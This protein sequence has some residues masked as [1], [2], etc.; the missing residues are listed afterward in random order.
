MRFYVKDLEGGTAT[1]LGAYAYLAAPTISSLT[2]ATG[3]TAGGNT[4]TIHGT[5][6][7]TATSVS[8]GSAQATPTVV[9]DTQL[10]VAVP[11]GTAAGA[12]TIGV[13][14][15]GGSVTATTTYQ[16]VDTPT[17]EAL[18]PNAGPTTGG[19][20]VTITGT[21]FNT[22][23]A[24]TFGGT[25]ASFTVVSPTQIV[26]L[27]PAGTAGFVDVTVTTAGGS[28]T[29]SEA[30]T[31]VAAPAFILSPA[32]GPTSGGTLVNIR[33]VNLQPTCRRRPLS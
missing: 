23:L 8:F 29:A 12:I 7:S 5:G 28:A 10:V 25:P 22:T 2:P 17:L 32:S 19:N 20:A 31:Y 3:P 16:Y 4:I 18:S 21:G 11:A 33:G 6:F 30:Y 27:A 15:S 14:T 24:V 26:A 13:T 9:N 1:N